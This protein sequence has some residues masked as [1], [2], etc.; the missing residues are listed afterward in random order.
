MEHGGRFRNMKFRAGS[1]RRSEVT[2]KVV[3]TDILGRHRVRNPALFVILNKSEIVVIGLP[4]P[5]DVA[6]IFA[7]CFRLRIVGIDIDPAVFCKVKI[8]KWP[9]VLDKR[10]S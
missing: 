10:L 7:Q 6:E 4:C 9:A 3:Q 2:G 5:I 8:S 1:P